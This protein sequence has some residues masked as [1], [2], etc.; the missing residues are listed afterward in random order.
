[1]F[2]SL[3]TAGFLAVILGV[4]DNALERLC[5]DVDC[6]ASCERLQTAPAKLFRLGGSVEK[7]ADVGRQPDIRNKPSFLLFPKTVPKTNFSPCA[8]RMKL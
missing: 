4:I 1:M 8:F 2:E 6:L 7:T 3:L 5:A